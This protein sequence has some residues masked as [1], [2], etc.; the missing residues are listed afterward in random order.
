MYHNG[1]ITMVSATIQRM[2]VPIARKT[3]VGVNATSMVLPSS[4]ILPKTSEIIVK[5]KYSLFMEILWA[6]RKGK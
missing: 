4:M 3:Q 6:K 2:M 1:A 5:F